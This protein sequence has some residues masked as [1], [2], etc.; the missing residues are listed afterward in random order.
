L[1]LLVALSECTGRVVPAG[2]LQPGPDVSSTMAV[3][4]QQC[5]ATCLQLLQPL[6][7]MGYSKSPHFSAVGASQ[8]CYAAA[9]RMASLWSGHGMV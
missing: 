9:L 6:I 3:Q 7:L 2:A 8:Q 1:L 5:C 4:Q